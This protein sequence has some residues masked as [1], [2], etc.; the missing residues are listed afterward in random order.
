LGSPK[1]GRLVT[2]KGPPPFL[3]PCERRCVPVF[4]GIGGVVML[5]LIILLLIYLL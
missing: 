2:K 5:V 4:Y 1:G 3:F